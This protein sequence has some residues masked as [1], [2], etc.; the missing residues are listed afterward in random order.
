MLQRKIELIEYLERKIMAKNKKSRFL[1]VMQL[2]TWIKP[3]R[4]LQEKGITI[5]GG[6]MQVS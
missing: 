2:K 5:T 3:L 1:W 6:P 4:M